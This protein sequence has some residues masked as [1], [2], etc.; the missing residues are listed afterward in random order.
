MSRLALPL[1]LAWGW[2][3]APPASAADPLKVDRTIGKEPAYKTRSPRYGLLVFGADGTDR[4]WLVHDGDTLYVDRNGNGDLTDPGEKVAAE[5]PKDRTPEEGEFN[6]EVGDLTVGGQTHKGV[7]VYVNPLS[8]YESPSISRRPDVKAALAKDPKAVVVTVRADVEVPGVKGGGVGGRL[9][10]MAGFLDL[11]GVLQ[12]AAKPADAPVIH[13]GGPLEVSFYGELPALRVG[14]AGEFVLVVG[15]PGD[16]PGTFAMLGYTDTIPEDAKP[17][18]EVT[19]RP[20][21]PGDPPVKEKFE[22][23]ERC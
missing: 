9:S 2:L 7:G 21:K 20:A 16:G 10:F 19:Y 18:A 17:V 4:V 13:L 15:T 6:F 11:N 5:K 8:R 1:A 3:L 23:K 14:R 22:I 12:F